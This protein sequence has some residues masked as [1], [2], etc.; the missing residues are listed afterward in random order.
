MGFADVWNRT[1][2]YFGIAEED[3]D[4]DEDGYLTEE[5]LERTYSERPNVRRLT[6][7]RRQQ[8]FDDW[9]DPE[10]EEEEP[11]RTPAPRVPA[12][13]PHGRRGD[14]V[15]RAVP[16]VQVHLV[17]PRSFNDAQQIADRFKDSMP[18]ILNLQGS[19]QELSK[20]F[21]DVF[22]YVYVLLIFVYVLTSW[23]RLPYTPWVR[24]I[25]DFLRDVCEPYLRLFRRILPPLGP[26]DLSPVVAIVVLFVLMRVIDALFN[27]FS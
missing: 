14:G 9:T 18:V 2:V 20:Q 4:W 11:T 19:D 23:V 22:I 12:S 17:V 25:S 26:L 6:P 1:L 8:D 5:D 24:R 27:S 7:R 3:D 10:P 21:I 13:R 16:S 15:V